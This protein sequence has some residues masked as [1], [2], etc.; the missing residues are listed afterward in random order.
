MS[1]MEITEASHNIILEIRYATA[2]NF[3][4]QPIYDSNRC[5]LR[6]EALNLLE[7][8]I[9]LAAQQGLRFKILDTY[10]PQYAQERLWSIC[11][12][13]DYV[14]PP[15]RGSPH[16]RGVAIDLT[17]IDQNGQELDM[18]TPFDSFDITSHH[19]S[20]QI[21]A[22]A[23]HNRYKLLGIMM[24]AGWDLFVNEWWHYQLFNA[25][26]FELISNR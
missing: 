6:P 3:T 11:P 25:R 1:L 26:Q 7:K 21:S 14:T 5:F 10:R 24:S 22:E 17:L 18:G 20:T 13:S 8:A 2:N 19:G 4:N 12:N 23:A 9:E 16:T 15:E